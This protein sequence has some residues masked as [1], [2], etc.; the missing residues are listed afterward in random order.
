[1]PTPSG[2]AGLAGP[3]GGT[4][5]GSPGAGQ[6]TLSLLKDDPSLEPLELQGEG[7]ARGKLLSPEAAPCPDPG[8]HPAGALTCLAP[9]CPQP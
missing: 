7:T 2:G 3:Q 9:S 4:G 8:H 6:G 5:T 1:M